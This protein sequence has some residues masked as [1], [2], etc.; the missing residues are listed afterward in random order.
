[1]RPLVATQSLTLVEQITAHSG[2]LGAHLSQSIHF[3][4]L[5]AP[6]RAQPSNHF[7]RAPLQQRARAA[8][9]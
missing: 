9:A 1:M 5:E 8:S 2:N 6:E 7:N 3:G 4:R